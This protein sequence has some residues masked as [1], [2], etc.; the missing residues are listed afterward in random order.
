MNILLILL[1]IVVLAISIPFGIIAA[2][3]P[4]YTLGKVV[5][6][7]GLPEAVGQ[8]P[9]GAVVL[10]GFIMYFQDILTVKTSAG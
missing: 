5:A 10:V 9:A 7:V 6:M 2:L 4:A 3:I 1:R 8:Y